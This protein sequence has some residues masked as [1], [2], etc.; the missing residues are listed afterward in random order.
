MALIYLVYR[1]E[2]SN[3]NTT[4]D[5]NE[6]KNHTSISSYTSNS[7][8]N[9][10]NDNDNNNNIHVYKYI[11]IYIY[12]L[13]HDYVYRERERESERERERERERETSLLLTATETLKGS[14]THKGPRKRVRVTEA[15]LSKC[16]LKGS[17][18]R[19]PL[20]ARS[21]KQRKNPEN[22]VTPHPQVLGGCQLRTKLLQFLRVH[23]RGTDSVLRV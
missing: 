4:T 7:N 18:F 2:Y 17:G 1:R 20:K 12:I 11:Y 8:N 14:L 21:S 3:S 23:L 10:D 19:V 13:C 16:F 6:K 9:N 15:R 5:D 22:M